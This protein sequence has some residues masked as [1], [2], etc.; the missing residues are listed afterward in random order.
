MARHIVVTGAGGWIG[1]EIVRYAGVSGYQVS[2]IGTAQS[3]SNRS[4]AFYPAD[5]STD[6]VLDL[7]SDSA[8]RGAETIVHC[9]GYA[10]RPRETSDEIARFDAVNRVGT[11][12]VV[13][14][15]R[16]LQIRRIVYVSSIA[17]YDWERG[18]GFDEEGPVAPTTAYAR[19]KLA[20]E[21]ACRQSGLDWRVARLATVFGD[22]DRANFA[23]LS[24]ALDRRRFLLPGAGEA[25]KSV[26]PVTLAAELLVDL[27]VRDHVSE[28]L[29]NLALPETPTLSEVCDSFSQICGFRK[30]RH[31]SLPLLRILA[32]V[33][34]LLAQVRPN[35][36]LTTRNLRKL[37]TSTTVCTRR[38]ETMWRERQWATFSEALAPSAPYYRSIGDSN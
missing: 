16:R 14:L 30:A 27:A 2:A 20:G 11:M 12:R 28:R 10:H 18:T 37:T 1:G 5:I 22:G 36:P 38:M 24:A 9:A 7:A 17:F 26:L 8:L 33:G 23:K 3:R 13:E 34:D 4:T 15:A 21:E 32:G 35:F 31:I 19:S 25:R 29:L 6:A